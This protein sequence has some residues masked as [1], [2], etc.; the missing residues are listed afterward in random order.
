MAWTEPKT[1]WKPSDTFGLEPDYARIR[2]NILHLAGMARRLYPAVPLAEMAEYMAADVPG[3][4]FFAAVDGNADALL[5]GCY[6]PA[7][8]G[9]GR[10]Y[11]AN[12]PIWSAD[13]LARIERALG[14]L[15]EILGAEENTRPVL[16]FTM[17]GDLFGACI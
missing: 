13:D 6:R 11:A 16:A 3:A 8:A 10:T 12:G 4:D 1:D 17:G 14:A 9:R 15:H 5:D 2:G 7:R